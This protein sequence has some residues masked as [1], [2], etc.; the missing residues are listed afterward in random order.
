[1]R[2]AIIKQDQYNNQYEIGDTAMID[3]DIYRIKYIV[4]QNDVIFEAEL[5]KAY[6]PTRD[7]ND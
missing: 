5:D 1:M 7:K 6:N 4:K 2:I 3:R